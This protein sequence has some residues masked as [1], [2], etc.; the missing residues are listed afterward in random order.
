M[1]LKFY[2]NLASEFGGKIKVVSLNLT[3]K[4]KILIIAVIF[5][6]KLTYVVHFTTFVL[7]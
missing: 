4:F 1:I 2:S 7:T 6:A 5:G 3:A